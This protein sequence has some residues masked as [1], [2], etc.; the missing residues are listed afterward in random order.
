MDGCKSDA[1]K[2]CFCAADIISAVEFDHSGYLAMRDQGDR[3][4][5]FERIEVSKSCQNEDELISAFDER[6]TP[7]CFPPDE[8]RYLTEFQSHESE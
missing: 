6:A 3:V 4:V 7:P 5:L 2:S 8:Y 1:R